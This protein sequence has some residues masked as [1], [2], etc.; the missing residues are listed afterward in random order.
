MKVVDNDNFSNVVLKSDVPVLVDFWG[1]WCKQLKKSMQELEDESDG[2]YKVCLADVEENDEYV[3][4]YRVMSVPTVICFKNG[5]EVGRISGLH[6]KDE[7]LD[8]LNI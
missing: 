2:K 1:V 6:S 5:E 3:N 8:L 7:Y 4:E